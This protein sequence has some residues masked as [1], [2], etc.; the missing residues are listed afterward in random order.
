M[1]VKLTKK[2]RITKMKSYNIKQMEQEL[3]LKEWLFENVL[4]QDFDT[5]EIIFKIEGG[6]S[7]FWE[8]HVYSKITVPP[9]N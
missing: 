4:G 9:N 7:K 5:Q 3:E 1:C 6:E 8:K 2:V